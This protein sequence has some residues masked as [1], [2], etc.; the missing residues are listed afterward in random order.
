MDPFST[1]DDNQA[2]PFSGEMPPQPS[3]DQGLLANMDSDGVPGGDSFGSGGDF[4]SGMGAPQDFSMPEQFEQVDYANLDSTQE[5]PEPEMRNALDDFNDQWEQELEQKKIEEDQKKMEMMEK[6]KQDLETFYQEKE[7][8]TEARMSKNRNEEQVLLEQLEADLE[9]DN[10]WERITKLVELQAEG[11]E[12]SVDV[13]R[14]RSLLIQLKNEPLEI[15]HAI[16][17]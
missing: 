14:M 7:K 17:A 2:D 10:S 3:G 4:T 9:S 11:G 12:G 8:Q 13:S 16:E 1:S 15:H 5:I 6:A